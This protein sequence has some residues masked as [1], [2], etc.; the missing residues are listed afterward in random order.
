MIVALIVAVPEATPV[1]TPFVETVALVSSSELK[2]NPVVGATNAAVPSLGTA[3]TFNAFVPSTANEK[4]PPS[5]AKA[6]TLSYQ[7]ESYKISVIV[8]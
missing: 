3:N 6:V 5:I 2:V 7:F 1:T 4:S 8:A